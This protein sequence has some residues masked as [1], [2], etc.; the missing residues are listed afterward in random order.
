MAKQVPPDARLL[1]A[2]DY[3]SGPTPYVPRA[4]AG[5]LAHWL[6]ETARRHGE[7]VPVAAHDYCAALEIAD[8]AIERHR[9]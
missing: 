5:I 6:A 4:L 1:Q 9:S 7:G 2:A 8:L 3:L